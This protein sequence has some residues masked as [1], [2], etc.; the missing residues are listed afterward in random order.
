M[1]AELSTGGAVTVKVTRKLRASDFDKDECKHFLPSMKKRDCVDCCHSNSVGRDPRKGYR[2]TGESLGSLASRKENL[3]LWAN[4]T[5]DERKYALLHSFTFNIIIDSHT[6]HYPL[7]HRS[8][9]HTEGK[10]VYMPMVTDQR[11][12]ER[13]KAANGTCPIVNQHHANADETNGTILHRITCLDQSKF[14]LKI[15]PPYL[16]VPASEPGQTDSNSLR[17]VTKL[18][19]KA[20]QSYLDAGRNDNSAAVAAL[21]NTLTRVNFRKHEGIIKGSHNRYIISD[22]PHEAR[23]YYHPDLEDYIAKGKDGFY[24]ATLRELGDDE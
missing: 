1:D 8:Y 18:D 9:I 13:N 7:F 2:L 5:T 3:R 11:E 6:L 20:Y 4:D 14:P 19:I 16:L 22:H 23:A 12:H 10:P 24:Q 21:D 17:L 15:V